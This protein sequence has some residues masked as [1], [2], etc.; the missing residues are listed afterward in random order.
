M[1]VP[2]GARGEPKTAAEKTQK[3]RMGPESGRFKSRAGPS[4]AEGR[5]TKVKIAAER[6]KQPSADAMPGA[7][8][9]AL[10]MPAA[11]PEVGKN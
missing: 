4:Q 2:A 5:G 10:P 6:T 3:K 8:G 7:A 9:A 1:K 11:H